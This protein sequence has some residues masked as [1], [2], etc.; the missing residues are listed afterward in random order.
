MNQG[1]LTRAQRDRVDAAVQAIGNAGLAVSRQMQAVVAHLDTHPENTQ[2]DAELALGIA[3]A[4]TAM[5]VAVNSLMRAWG[6][7][8]RPGQVPTGAGHDH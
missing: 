8:S 2:A 5:A 4:C 6:G 1:N 7:D 3:E